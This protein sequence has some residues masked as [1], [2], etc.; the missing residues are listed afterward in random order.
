VEVLSRVGYVVHGAIYLV[1]GALAALVAWGTRGELADPP[2]VIDILDKLPAGD[3]LVTLVAAGLAAYALWRFVQ[4]FAD[5]DQQG[6]TLK[7]L[8][9]RVGRVV[10]GIGYSALAVF[11]ARLAAGGS[12]NAGDQPN[13]A[14]RLLAEPLGTIAGGMIAI[15]LLCV[16]TD[17]ARKACTTNFGERLKH[18]EMSMLLTAANTCAGSWGFA[19]RAVVLIFGGIY[20]MRAVFLTEPHHAKGF[21]AILA[22]LLRLPQGEWVLGF[23]ALGLGAYGLFMIQAGLYRR[24]PY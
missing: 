18:H 15:I 8:V 17:D 6:R 12:Q 9:V 10:S 7:G 11:A 13:W 21:E 22:G 5:P 2:S 4:A 1:I 14:H 19:A 23:V 3:L 24:H 20:L 16:A